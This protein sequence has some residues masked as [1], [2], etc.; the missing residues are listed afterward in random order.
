MELLLL[1]L[2]LGLPAILF[3][4]QLSFCHAAY[5]GNHGKLLFFD[6]PNGM[7][8][9]ANVTHRGRG[10]SSQTIHFLTGKNVELGRSEGLIGQSKVLH[11]K[12]TGS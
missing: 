5:A 12:T 4:V 3:P 7:D 10:V 2:L 11:Q 8:I 1:L 6:G 9:T